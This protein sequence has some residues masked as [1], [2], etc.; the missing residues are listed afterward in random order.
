MQL[1][2]FQQN[3]LVTQSILSRLWDNTYLTDES[4]DNFSYIKDK[5]FYGE[6][7]DKVKLLNTGSWLFGS[8]QSTISFY[9]WEPE[10][11][12]KLNLDLFIQDFLAL[13]FTTIWIQWLEGKREIQYLPA[14]R[15]FKQ[16][17]A[18]NI[19]RTYIKEKEWSYTSN[20]DTYA[21][22]KTYEVWITYN[23]LYLLS[24]N[25]LT[26]SMQEVPLNTIWETS[27]LQPIEKTW[28]KTK[29]IFVIKKDENEQYPVSEFQTIKNIV[30]SIDRKIVM[31][32]TQ[33]LQNMESFVLLK[34]I[35][36]PK[37]LL[38]D[39][40]AWKRLNLSQLGRIV[41]WN[42][43]SSIEFINNINNL[44][45]ETKWTINDQIRQISSMT[46]I[47]IDFLWL[48]SKDGAIWE[49]SRTLKHWSF[50]KK[51]QSIRDMFDTYL[52]DILGALWEY[53]QI[54]RPDIFAKSNKE[55]V[56]ELSIALDNRII[57]RLNAIKQYN[58]FNDDEAEKELEN[59]NKEKEESLD[60]LDTTNNNVGTDW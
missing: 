47:P 55:L 18:D 42:Q 34:W 57:S 40:I 48:D 13:W 10:I 28:L 8:I 7:T 52:P 33:Y 51:I 49:W 11:E 27:H 9:V 19:M 60:I 41:Q 31:M 23:R 21:F 53:E 54:M 6:T 1:T 15:Y 30:Y 14:K 5:F 50:I 44:I 59:I 37:N 32:D 39:Y 56:E 36:L 43:D 58:W 35:N 20:Y 26:T 38:K 45:G 29:A 22:I 3:N 12:T 17:D 2:K 25:S 16:W 46:K 4:N 24:N